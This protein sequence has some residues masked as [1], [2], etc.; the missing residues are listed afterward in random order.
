MRGL[1][2]READRLE[3]LLLKDG[4]SAT[5]PLWLIETAFLSGILASSAAPLFV[6]ADHV[7]FLKPVDVGNFLR[8]KSC[9]LYT[10][11]ENPTRP[12]INVEVVAHVTRP[13]LRSSEVSN[14]FYFTFTARPEAMKDGLKIRSVVPATERRH[15]GCSNVWMLRTQN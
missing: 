12:L 14:T 15:G 10:E 9:V 1:E 7:D 8:L 5:C 4:S 11:L 13:E 6:E 2:D 3:A